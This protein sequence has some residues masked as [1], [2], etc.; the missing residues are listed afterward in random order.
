MFL[1]GVFRSPT[2]GLD[3][4][5]SSVKAV[6]LRRTRAGWALVGT[7]EAPISVEQGSNGSAVGSAIQ[8]VQATLHLAP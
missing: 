1:P 7:G 8:Q 2:I 3:V 6:A 5:S 4:G